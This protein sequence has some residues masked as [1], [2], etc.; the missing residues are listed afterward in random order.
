MPVKSGKG[1]A[2]SEKDS[3]FKK[4]K[5]LIKIMKDNDLVE[6]EIQNGDEKILLKRSHAQPAIT[7]IPMMGHAGG[8]T[9]TAA[10]GNFTTAA[11][12]E[13]KKAEEGLVEIKSQM[14]GTFYSSPSPDSDPYVEEGAHVSQQAVICIIEAMKVMNEIKAETSGTIVDVLVKNGQAVEFGQVLFRVKPD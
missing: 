2:M 13:A 11:Q 6:V 12:Q 5:E 1:I 14:V 3:D 8:L 10:G 9:N 7:A 4:I